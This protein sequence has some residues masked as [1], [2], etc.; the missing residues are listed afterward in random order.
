M[1]IPT[2]FAIAEPYTKPFTP[3][4]R[5]IIVKAA[6]QWATPAEPILLTAKCESGLNLKATNKTSKEFSVGIAQINLKAHTNITEAQA[7][8]P[9]FAANFMA[10]NF[11]KGKQSMWVCARKLNLLTK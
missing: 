3:S 1:W 11:S 10:E 4:V 2:K 6:Q 5:Q 9:V 7:R 8:D